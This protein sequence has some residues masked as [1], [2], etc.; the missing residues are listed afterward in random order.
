MFRPCDPTEILDIISQLET[1]KATGPNSIPTD[2]FKLIKNEIS[3]PLSKIINDSFS[4]GT[5]PDKLK[6][7]NVI[8]VFKKGSRLQVSNYRP[9]SLLSNINKIFEKVM[10]KRMTDFLEFHKNIYVRQF[11]FRSKHSTTNALIN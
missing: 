8:P 1:S 9:I 2:I 7:V 4:S 5:H 6:I 3:S 10:H 11:G